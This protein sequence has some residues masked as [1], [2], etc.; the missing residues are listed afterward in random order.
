MYK[1]LYKVLLADG[2]VTF[3][4]SLSLIG[5]HIA[6]HHWILNHNQSDSDTKSKDLFSLFSP[7]VLSQVYDMC[8]HPAYN[9][10]INLCIECYDIS[11]NLAFH[12]TSTWNMAHIDLA[13]CNEPAFTPPPVSTP[14]ESH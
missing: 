11:L 8:P 4:Q 12:I 14:S 1:T 13:T 3:L 6:T 10:I 7:M 9:P 2:T 5:T